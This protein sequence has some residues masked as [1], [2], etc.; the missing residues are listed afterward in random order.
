MICKGQ[1]CWN[2]W[3]GGTPI[4]GTPLYNG[5]KSELNRLESAKAADSPWTQSFDM[6]GRWLSVWI[7]FIHLHFCDKKIYSLGLPQS[8]GEDMLFQPCNRWITSRTVFGVWILQHGSKDPSICMENPWT[9]TITQ[10][11]FGP[12]KPMKPRKSQCDGDPNRAQ[13]VRTP[14][15]HAEPFRLAC[16]GNGSMGSWKPWRRCQPM[17]K[18]PRAKISD[19]SW[20]NQ[21]FGIVWTSFF[22]AKCS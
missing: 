17:L 1:S 12:M 15:A 13:I 2:G 5:Q 7:Q 20:A 9:S 6:I 16:S 11:K 22:V 4:Y 21:S 8:S 10:R 14:F 19:G 3:F 18:Q